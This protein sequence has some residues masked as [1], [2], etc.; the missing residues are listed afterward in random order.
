MPQE[1]Q[2]E[3]EK[4]TYQPVKIEAVPV[5]KNK[6]RDGS[7]CWAVTNLIE[8]AKGLPVFDLP[9]CCINVA[10]KVW[11]PIE[12]AKALAEHMKRV[13]EVD[14]EKPVILDE[15]GY[16]MDGWH[17]VARALLDGKVTIPAVRFEYTRAA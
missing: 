4:M 13:M 11:E 14:T 15:D 16:I 5:H 9:L 6:F 7:R 3:T 8:Q 12:G 17:R 1:T 2:T 10:S